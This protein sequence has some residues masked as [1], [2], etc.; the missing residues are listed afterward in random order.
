MTDYGIPSILFAYVE[1][2]GP[3]ITDIKCCVNPLEL[4]DMRCAHFKV[5]INNP[6]EGVFAECYCAKFVPSAGL[7]TLKIFPLPDEEEN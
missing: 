4:C 2:Y 3:I 6:P 1:R 7:K 5:G